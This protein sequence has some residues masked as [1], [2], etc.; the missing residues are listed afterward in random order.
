[1]SSQHNTSIRF[2]SECLRLGERADSWRDAVVLAGE[3]LRTI[4]A[5]RSTYAERMI[6]V[7]ETFGPYVVVAPGVALVHARPDHDVLQNA[8]AVVTLPDGVAFGH[9]ENDP[10]RVVVA[11]A[12]TRPEEHIKIVAVIAKLLDDAG[13]AAE[14]LLSESDPEVL[15]AAIIERIEPLVVLDASDESASR[16]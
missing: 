3:V 10:V 5:T 11:L 9:P 14:L 2:G 7:I 6:G 16:G 15:A 4:G 8:A 13:T 12:V 1:M